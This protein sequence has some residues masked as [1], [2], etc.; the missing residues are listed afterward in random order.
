MGSTETGRR[1]ADV[2]D[3]LRGRRVRRVGR[4]HND[5]RALAPRS[6]SVKPETTL[7][8][9]ILPNPRSTGVNLFA[10]C[11]CPSCTAPNTLCRELLSLCQEIST[12]LCERCGQTWAN[13]RRINVA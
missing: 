13:T 4:R 2:S 10:W 3:E 8:C 12:F 7:L 5:R 11:S 1:L 9:G 6:Q